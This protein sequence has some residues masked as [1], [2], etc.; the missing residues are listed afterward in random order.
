MVTID[1]YVQKIK[2]KNQSVQTLK[3]KQD[4]RTDATDCI[5]LPVNV[6]GNCEIN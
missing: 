6:V 2:I 1:I 3:W 4:G 5:T